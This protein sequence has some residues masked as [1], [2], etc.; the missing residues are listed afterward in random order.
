VS[1]HENNL[2]GSYLRLRRQEL[3]WSQTTAAAKLNMSRDSLGRLERGERVVPSIEEVRSW[4]APL[5][6]ET[7]AVDPEFLEGLRRDTTDAQR[8]AVGD[9]SESSI[10][11]VWPLFPPEFDAEI[12]SARGR[13][14]IWQTWMPFDLGFIDSLSA[15]I[16]NGARSRFLLLDPAGPTARRRAEALRYPN[17]EGHLRAAMTVLIAS[18]LTIRDFDIRASLRFSNE[19]PPAQL[20]ATERR[21]VLGWFFPD[22]PSTVMPQVDVASHSPLGKVMLDYF[23]ATWNALAEPDLREYH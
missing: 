22:R 18:L 6:N 23:E 8:G 9:T 2:L 3:G 15:A 5:S 19:F 11:K 17:P 12:S 13:V 20:Y 10:A 21:V 16:T 14:D 4:A 1:T 7:H